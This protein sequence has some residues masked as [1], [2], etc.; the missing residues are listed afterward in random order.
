MA[1]RLTGRLVS[2]SGD[3]RF[4]GRFGAPMFLRFFL[5]LWVCFDLMFMT[6][7]LS[8]HPFQQGAPWFLIPFLLV[9]LLAPFGITA[10]SM[11]GANTVCQRLIDFVIATGSGQSTG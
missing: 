8:D 9:H 10:I 1:P 5:V 2:S 6:A 3:T 7:M 11:V 4:D